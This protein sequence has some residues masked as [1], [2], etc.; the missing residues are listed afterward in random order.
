MK[1]CIAAS[2]GGHMT[3]AL[4]L[5]PAYA[6]HEVFLI[7]YANPRMGGLPFRICM[8]P[9]FDRNPLKLTAVLWKVFTAFRRER[10][11]LVLSTG[12]EIAIPVFLMAKL[13]RA[14]TVFIETLTRVERP[15]LT[16]RILYPFADRFY[17][18]NPESLK[19][20]GPRAEYHGGIV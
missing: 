2:D 20:F 8:V 16:A 18:Q 9:K 12:A 11:K 13:F 6:G 4:F 15:S 17:V 1:I 19:S 3:E 7:T 10:P 5:R 14:K